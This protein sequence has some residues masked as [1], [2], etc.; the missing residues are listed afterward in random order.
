[1]TVPAEVLPIGRVRVEGVAIGGADTVRAAA[2]VAF[3]DEWVVANFDQ[4]L[5]LLRYFATEAALAQLRAAS[6][7]E[8][9]QVWRDF[10][11][12]SDP[13][14]RTAE[15][16]ALD[17]YFRRLQIANDRF[18]EGSDPGWTTDRGEVFISLGEPDE[19]YDSS[20]DLQG[21][22]GRWIRWTYISLRLTLNFVD[23]SG[24]GRFRLDGASRSAFQQA[25]ERLRFGQ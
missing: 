3:S 24:F 22:G 4:T 14:P 19:V 20:S 18:R 15:H 21:R 6:L 16:E 25:R 9:P 17:A 11:E 1:M 8:R 5:S 12:R 2:L 13:D 7:E 23:E 10:W